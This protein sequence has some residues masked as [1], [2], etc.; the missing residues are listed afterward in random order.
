MNPNMTC[1]VSLESYHPYLQPQKVLKN[2]IFFAFTAACPKPLNSIYGT[3]MPLGVKRHMK[4][5][6]SIIITKN[7]TYMKT[8]YTFAKM[9][10]IMTF[11]SIDK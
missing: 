1:S 4:E 10:K 7:H 3:H 11:N 9:K 2:P 5:T 8:I 6:I